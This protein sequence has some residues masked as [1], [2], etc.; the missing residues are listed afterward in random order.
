MALGL[1]F[2]LGLQ[3]GGANSAL[4]VPAIIWSGDTSDSTPDFDV[5]LPD[6]ATKVNDVLY[7]EYSSD[8]GSN[9]SD[10]FSR[11]LL[12]GEIAGHSFTVSGISPLPN[13][14]YMFRARLERG[15]LIG[16]WCAS[17]SVT[18]N[19]PNKRNVILVMRAQ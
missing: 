2:G 12:I 18:I 13:G 1:G 10:Y 19:V 4:P 6:P 7:L 15:M 9:W 14:S 11:T 16:F 5:Y 3:R 17:E 8:G